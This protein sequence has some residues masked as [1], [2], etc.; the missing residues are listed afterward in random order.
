[1]REN[2]G[3]V[4]CEGEGIIDNESWASFYDSTRAIVF[5][6]HSGFECAF[7]QLLF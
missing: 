1:M 3:D 4:S 6:R 2:T 7:L 5:P